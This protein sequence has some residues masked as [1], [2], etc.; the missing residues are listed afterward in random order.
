MKKL[1]LYKKIL[2]KTENIQFN[3]LFIYI[4]ANFYSGDWFR[5]I[6]L[7]LRE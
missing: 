5:V 3:K 7:I 2:K 1:T 6:G 4:F